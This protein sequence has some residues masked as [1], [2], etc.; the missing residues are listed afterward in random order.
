[1]DPKTIKLVV[2]CCVLIV[3]GV[4]VCMLLL[5]PATAPVTAC[6][7]NVC[8]IGESCPEDC[9]A[10]SC[11]AEGKNTTYAPRGAKC[12]EGLTEADLYTYAFNGKCD[13]L[14]TTGGTCIQCGNGICGPG[15]NKCNCPE[16]CNTL[17]CVGQG[18]SFSTMPR[19]D[20]GQD[21]NPC[22]SGLEPISTVVDGGV[23]TDCGNG[24]CDKY[25]ESGEE[26]SINC[27]EDC[28][29][30]GEVLTVSQ[31][32]TLPKDSELHSVRGFVVYHYDYCPPCP[33]GAAC[34]P[35]IFPFVI[36]SD[37]NVIK[38]EYQPGDALNTSEM[39]LEDLSGLESPTLGEYVM[40]VRREG[41]VDSAVSYHAV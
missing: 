41:S 27:P 29:E 8:A 3:V 34:A 17:N 26:T 16:D 21:L 22:C 36:L 13:L 32:N 19:P 18:E 25:G 5:K 9:P 39:Y 14:N 28:E 2:M 12:C 37:Y 6:G 23:C 24:V 33:A 38:Q 4:A 11:I 1:M 31:Y 10:S 20:G 7:D 40:V 30:L 35:C 15:E